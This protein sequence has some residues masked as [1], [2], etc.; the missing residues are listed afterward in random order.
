MQ[1]LIAVV[2]DLFVFA[3]DF[4]FSF[5]SVQKSPEKTLETSSKATIDAF[6]THLHN[7]SSRLKESPIV[8]SEVEK[9]SESMF[10]V[11]GV[12]YAVTSTPL[13]QNPGYEIDSKLSVIP[14]GTKLKTEA[15]K[16]G[17]IRVSHE[18]Y[19]GWVS[20][21][22]VT[23]EEESIVP[24]F[25]AGDPVDNQNLSVRLLREYINDEFSAGTISP[26]LLDIEYVLFRLKKIGRTPIWPSDRPRLAGLWQHLLRGKPGVHIAIRPLSEAVIE[27][28]HPTGVENIAFVSAVYPDMKIRIEGIY[29][30]DKTIFRDEV[31]AQ[32][33][34]REW[35]PVFISIT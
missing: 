32:E 24:N 29:G 19:V 25:A 4:L 11:P 31:F 26:Y 2:N 33:E 35:R 16:S 5:S 14:F 30:E 3:R 10:S 8:P 28:E 1:V 20:P 34:W 22:T 21:K 23:Q 9:M 12:V 6:E 17:W 27:Y 15:V 18:G 13:Y 7:A